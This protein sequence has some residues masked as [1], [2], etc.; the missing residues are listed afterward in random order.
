MAIRRI[1]DQENIVLDQKPQ[2]TT[3]RKIEPNEF[4]TLDQD[5]EVLPAR[6]TSPVYFPK[7]E[8]D[9]SIAGHVKSGAVDATRRLYGFSANVLD[10]AADKADDLQFQA[11]RTYYD[12][13]G[14]PNPDA[15]KIDE[16]TAPE[17]NAVSRGLRDQASEDIRNERILAGQESAMN[18]Q[19]TVAWEE[20]SPFQNEFFEINPA[21]AGRFILEQGARSLPE[22]GVAFI[23]YVGLP[24][25]ATTT[26][27]NIT[28]NRLQNEGK[29]PTEIPT[30]EDMKAALSA[31]LVS[32]GLER[33]GVLGD[34]AQPLGGTAKTVARA[35]DI[36]SAMVRSGAG[37]AGTEFVQE[38]TEY[39]GGSLGTGE[40]PTVKGFIE[41]GLQGALIGG[42]M[43]ATV[44][45]G[46]EGVSLAVQGKPGEEQK[47]LE[48]RTEQNLG[49]DA[50]QQQSAPTPEPGEVVAQIEAPLNRDDLAESIKNDTP[51]PDKK[52]IDLPEVEID[53]AL[54][55]QGYVVGATVEQVDENGEVSSGTVA[56]AQIIDDSL[57][58]TIVD[59]D[60]NLK[61]LFSSNGDIAVTSVPEQQQPTPPPAQQESGQIG[62]DF[63]APLTPPA[64]AAPENPYAAMTFEQLTSNLGNIKQQ[65]KQSGWNK[66]LID[67]RKQINTEIEARFPGQDAPKNIDLLDAAQDVAQEPTDAQKEAGNYKKGHV[68]V[69]GLPVTLENPKGSVR[70]G[71]DASGQE[72]SVTMPA[73]Y[74]YI[75]RTNGADGE[76]ID[77]YIGDQPSSDKVY[78]LDQIDAETRNFDE[79]KAFVGFESADQVKIA[80]NSSFSDGL[81]SQRYGGLTEMTMAEFK[82]WIKKPASKKPLVYKKQDQ[83]ETEGGAVEPPAS[84]QSNLTNPYLSNITDTAERVT[85]LYAQ[86]ANDEVLR[87]IIT[88]LGTGAEAD[89]LRLAKQYFKWLDATPFAFKTA[90][91]DNAGARFLNRSRKIAQTEEESQTDESNNQP[92]AG[93]ESGPETQAQQPSDEADQDTA[94]GQDQEQTEEDQ[95][96]RP[97]KKTRMVAGQERP[98]PK[99]A[100]L[101][102]LYRMDKAVQEEFAAVAERSEEVNDAAF[103]ELEQYA[104]DIETEIERL[105]SEDGQKQQNANQAEEGKPD[106]KKNSKVGNDYFPKSKLQSYENQST[107]SREIL[108]Q[109]TPDDFLK[110]ALPIS[111]ADQSKKGRV[112]EI[113]GRREKFT[114]LPFMSFEHDGNGNAK[115]IAHE[116][117]HRAE[118]LKEFG[119]KTIP[120]VFIS[121]EGGGGQAIRWGEQSNTNSPDVIEGKWPAKLIS[122]NGKESIEF[123]VKDNR[124]KDAV[125]SPEPETPAVDEDAPERKS[126]LK[127]VGEKLEGGRKF[128]ENLDKA[129]VSEKA[130]L[131]IEAT[132]PAQAF[133]Y[134]APEG[135]TSGAVRF[136]QELMRNVYNFSEYLYKKHILKKGKGGRYGRK[137][138][139]WQEQVK[140]FLSDQTTES[141]S[142]EVGDRFYS[143]SMALTTRNDIIAASEEYVEFATKINEIFENAATVEELRI[144]FKRE[145]GEATVFST[146]LD[147][148]AKSYWLTRDIVK[149]DGYGTFGRIKDDTEEKKKKGPEKKLIRPRLE[150]IE[151]ENLKDF[152]AG[153][154]VTPEEFRSTFGFRGVEFGNWVN[155]AEGQAHVNHAYDALMDLARRLKIDPK[156]I[157]IGGKL[158]FAFG[159]RG[160]GEHAAHYEPDTNVINLTKTKGDGSVAHEWAHALDIN[161]RNTGAAGR[162]FMD[163]AYKSLSKKA[164]TPEDL[165]QKIK[166]FLQG[167]IFYQHMKKAGPV[168]NAREHLRLLKSKPSYYALR[169]TQ[170]QKDGNDLSKNYHGTEIELFARAWEAWVYDTL[171]G[172]SPYL[173]SPWVA[174]GAVT[175]ET[176][177]RGTMYP[178]GEERIGFNAMF[179]ELLKS[180]Q[181]TDTGV[182]LKEN[183]KLPFEND[184]DAV[185]KAAD[186]IEG[187]LGQMMK[188][189]EDGNV[190]QRTVQTGIS[191]S[192]GG[193]ST[194]F[195]PPDDQGQDAEA[196]PQGDSGRSGEDV[197]SSI[198]TS[199]SEQ[200]DGAESGEGDSSRDRVQ[201]DD[202]VPSGVEGGTEAFQ[203]KGKNHVISLGDLSES[204][205]QKQKAEDNIKIIKLVKEIEGARRAATPEEQVIIAKFTGWGSIKNAFPDGNGNFKEGW[206]SI[207]TQLKELL[208]DKEY[209]QSR[210]TIQYAHYTSEIV[211]RQMWSAL[212]RFGL[213][214]GNIFEPGMGIGNFVGMM[215]QDLK[216]QYSGLEVD[217]M[218]ARIAAILYPESGVRHAD[219]IAAQYAD[220]MFDAAIGNPPFSETKIRSDKKYRGLS[221]HNYFFAKTLDMVADG[222]VIAFVT[223]RFS[224]DALDSKARA[225]LAEKADLIGAI[226]LPNTAFKTNAHTE[227]VTDIV[228]LRKRLSGEESNGVKW[229]ETEEIDVKDGE[230][231]PFQINEYFVNNPEMVLGDFS[232]TGSMHGAKNALTVNPP[233][234]KDLQQQLEEAIARLPE[235]IVTD[236]ERSS[237][238][239]IDLEPPEAKDGS[240][241]IKDG[242]LMQVENGIG[243]PAP[244]R[245]KAPGGLTKKEAEKVKKLIPVRDAL[246]N[247]LSA[248]VAQNDGLMRK[249]Q[250]KLRKHY[251]AFVKK[252]GPI[253]KSDTV[254]RPPA[255]SQLEEARDEMR[256]D[257]IAAGEEFEEGDIDLSNLLGKKNPETG[258]RY[259]PAQIAKIRQIKRT[260]IE[261]KGGVV[262]EG[263]FDPA[264]VPDNVTISYPNMDAFRAD[265]EYYNFIVLENYDADTDTATTTDVFEKNIVRQVTKPKIETSVDALNYSLAQ[266]NGVDIDF[267]AEES[268]TNRDSLIRELEELD[269]IFSVPNPEGGEYHMYAEEYLSGLVRDKL[270]YAKRLA[271]K[272]QKYQRNVEALQAVQPRDIPASDI[273]TQLGSPYFDPEVIQDFM[274]EE[275][276]IP[277][278][279]TYSPIINGWDVSAYDKYASENTSQHGTKKRPADDLISSLL[280]RKDIKITKKV[281]TESGEKSVVDID[282]TQ[283]AQDKAKALQEKFDNWIWKSKHGERVHRKY[284][285][286][287]NNLVPRRID[288]KHITVAST[289]PLR[290]HQKNAVW[291]I[292]QTGNSYLAHAVGAGKT[293]EMVAAAMEMRRLG[294]WKKPLFVVPNHMLAQFAGEFRIA[295]PQAKI[296]VA[297][298]RNF[299][300]SKRQRFVANVAKG[301]WDGVIMTYSSFKKVPISKEFEAEMIQDEIERYRLALEEANRSKSSGRGSTAARL[302]KQIEKM[303]GRLKGLKLQDVDQGFSFDQLGTDAI[304]LD[305]AHYFRKLSFATMQGN[306]KGVNPIGSKAAWDLYVKAKYL[307][308]VHPGRNLVMASGTP[309]TNTLAEVFTIQRFMNEAALEARNIATFDAWS[310]VYA[311]SVT[312][313]ERQPSG[314]YKNVTRLAEFRNLNSLSQ[315]VREFMDVVTSDE[316]GALVDRPTMKTGTMIIKTTPPTREYL[317]FQKFLAERTK[318]ISNK[319]TNEKGADNILAIINE[320]RHAAIDMRLIDPTLPE[321]RSKL[322]DMIEN[323]FKV[324]KDTA[325]DEFTKI[326]K[327]DEKSDI[328]GGAQLIFSDLGVRSRMKNGQSFSAYDHIR[329]KLIR[330]GVP[331]DEI[332][333]IADYD[334]TEEKRRL[335]AKVRAGEVRIL[336]GSTSKMGTGLNVQNRLKA[337]HNLD[338]PWLPADLEQRTG[339]ALRQGNQY[340]EVEIYGYG[341]EGSYDSTM[342]GMLETKAKAIIQ[343]LKGDTDLTTMR[344]I[345]E[346]DHYRMAKAMTSGDERVLKQAEL[347]SEVEKLARQSKN[348]INEQVQIKSSIASN[349]SSI[350]HRKQL[351]KDAEQALEQ[352]KDFEDEEFL[353]SVNGTPY[354]ERAEAAAALEKSV[355]SVIDNQTSTPSDGVKIADY[356]GFEV[357]MFASIS[358]I[359]EE[360]E[361]FIPHPAFESRANRNDWVKGEK[362]SGSGA[363]TRL[364]NAVNRLNSI[365]QDSEQSIAR[366]EREIKVL[367]SQIND[368]FPKEEELKKKREELAAVEKDLKENAPV[369]VVYDDY[370]LDYW[371]ANKEE[372][373][374]SV[375]ASFYIV[376]DEE[377]SYGR[378]APKSDGLSSEMAEKINN[379]LKSVGWPAANVR[380]S[381][382]LSQEF[383]VSDVEGAYWRGIIHI[384]MQAQDIL[385]TLNHEIIHGLKSFGAF[386]DTEWSVL[387]GRAAGWRKKYN[388]DATYKAVLQEQGVTDPALMERKLNEE[389]IAHAFQDHANKGIVRRLANKAVRFLQTIKQIL[390]GKP[391]NFT[392]AED[393][394]RAVDS[395]EVGARFSGDPQSQNPLFS[396]TQYVPDRFFRKDDPKRFN[397]PVPYKGGR[398]SGFTTPEHSVF[399]GYDKNG[400]QFTISVDRVDPKDIEIRGKHRSAKTAAWLRK[401]LWGQSSA[402]DDFPMY[403]LG[404]KKD[405][406]LR[407]AKKSLANVR[408][409]ETN[410]LSDLKRASSLILHPHQIATLYKEFTPVYRAVI[411]RFKQ[412]EILVHQL[413]KHIDLYNKLSEDSKKNVNAV[414]EIG[415]LAGRTYKPDQSGAVIVK[416]SGFKDTVHSEDGDTITLTPV[417]AQAYL[418]V[419]K[420]LDEALELQIQV[421]LEEYGLRELG[422]KTIQ[423]VEKLRLKAVKE[424]MAAEVRR[425]KQILERLNEVENMRKR[426]YVP[427]KRW[428]EVGVSVKDADGE[429]KYFTRVELPKGWRKKGVIGENKAVQE[430]LDM[431]AEKYKGKDYQINFFEMNKFDEVAAYL[432]LRALDILASSSDMSE[433]D[434]ARLKDMLEREMQKKG[435]RSHFFRSLDVPGY[436]PDF[437]RALNDYV[438]SSASYIARRL[439]ERH[440]DAAVS[441]IAESGKP[442]LY[443]YARGYQ[444]YVNDPKEELAGIRMMG[445]FWYLA[446]NV[447]SGL[448]NMTQPLI[449]TAPWFSAKFG[450]AE[451]GKEM[452]KAYVDAGKTFDPKSPVQEPF[453]FD[454]A[455]ADIRKA[456]KKAQAEGDFLSMATHDAMAISNSTTQSLRGLSKKRRQVADSIA[457]TF[458][459]PE[460]TNR[461][462]TFISAYR[463]AMK[464]ENREKI[465]KFV[466]NDQLARSMLRGQNSAE[467][468]AFAYAELAVVS[469]QYRVGKLNRP[470]LMRGYGSLL[471]QFMSFTTQTFELMYKLAKVNGGR[472]K[473]A[474][475]TMLLSVVAVAGMKGLPFEDDLQDL[476]ETLYKFFTGKELDIDTEIRELLSE[477]TNPVIADTLIRGV[478]AS[479]LNLDLSGRLGFGNVAP[480]RGADFLGPWWDMLYERPKRAAKLANEGQPLAA[481]SEIAPAFIRNP[482]QSLIWA[483]DGVRTRTG[484]KVIDAKDVTTTDAALKFFGFTSAD[485]SKE[486][487]R[488]WA[489]SRANNAV[490]DLRSRYYKKISKTIAERKRLYDSGDKAGAEQMSVQLEAIR[491]EINRYN[492]TAPLHEKIILHEPTIK[493]RLLEEMEGA[494]VRRIRKQARPRSQELKEIYK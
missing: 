476:Y 449:V 208:T 242:A 122:E 297:D 107:K 181:F 47:L 366:S 311:S 125:Q 22:M 64:P 192:D 352:K 330:M 18:V 331:S 147:K 158:G 103:A 461:V 446:G 289:I 203:A 433:T 332:A 101:Q 140:I 302:E 345:E 383:G 256:N 42:P 360:Y 228:F 10:K 98:E 467:A 418:G 85:K 249:E 177:Y 384:S 212:K 50:Q 403:K 180:I 71:K 92:P 135:Q 222:G 117:R 176:G 458:S 277:A 52:V 415:R 239:G 283:A 162:S 338:A 271:D 411:E 55:Q 299:H 370:P 74:G 114:D 143:N 278:K 230:G 464:P 396:K 187:R 379:R 373:K 410:L 3:L 280:M 255:L 204:R 402:N 254:S 318:E 72:W 365:K 357:R 95:G 325:G 16:M 412:R 326:Y 475:A 339:R 432:D 455:P 295:Y 146:M 227:V 275:L 368:K 306:M 153:K 407:E 463:L 457:V 155:A 80:Y 431:L 15:S 397:N 453:D 214:T 154:D 246:R 378:A 428:G 348:F 319:R 448:V 6:A 400:E 333:F 316:L 362:F 39:V 226:R 377:F 422:V 171:D 21:K 430:V 394:F 298:E 241:Y 156:H 131:I 13:F 281:T 268:G 175:K 364:N 252:Y 421:I 37:E 157:S 341:T 145:L 58:V 199:Q 35:R 78:V 201:R 291:R 468:F 429:L 450:L 32:A 314:A 243:Q 150:K 486:R 369:E 454:K 485:I 77:V 136:H 346:T 113:L 376:G 30:N 237:E 196:A 284:N 20:I 2:K 359:I 290:E 279:V 481:A 1:G 41:S 391:Y 245:G 374:N 477:K 313:A 441:S 300:T 186:D 231:N 324:Y 462:V 248:M 223:S 442:D 36:P 388:I 361:I 465:E 185:I 385:G 363:I 26:S 371:R 69:Q 435:F 124:Q 236:I 269:L 386:T 67:A 170:F 163:K 109:M 382:D 141:D 48:D 75:K 443:E 7:Q 488:V 46:T 285:Q 126:K 82:E 96:D 28:E 229:L 406:A 389:A 263:S 380:F 167:K 344:D 262:D 267:M 417:E 63:D 169:N 133:A 206:Q 296:Y 292:L 274:Q 492:Q 97:V 372:I 399:F 217:P 178:I 90:T 65:A 494:R 193:T 99:G 308:T 174:D 293:L 27:Q 142:V 491:D 91:E 138:P 337:V 168:G 129:P 408:G 317:A 189:I 93:D 200:G 5:R 349:K 116:G 144:A 460:K 232:A 23:P 123:P 216:L 14:Y 303:E 66:K 247:V 233:V 24:T 205:S 128:K 33:L 244:M 310:S 70:S 4:I 261:E 309:L 483:N 469:T 54:R 482:L 127:D 215:P 350:D 354:Q 111:G 471:F 367:E 59:A 445:F 61:T 426:G 202:T 335:Q 438:I 390:S 31:G 105:K 329:R 381:D 340:G 130:K 301:D 351:I 489:E 134:T 434:Y 414:L 258:K 272:D 19:D 484:T 198:R 472:N 209:R 172:Q 148:F 211:T 404:K 347:E 276:N 115:I 452:S 353:M 307:D 51:L 68:S 221:L 439:N 238:V 120:V 57:E 321:S 56:A 487:A 401:T 9:T 79:H 161:L 305:E 108:I 257:Y 195:I 213:K 473:M 8:M 87:N 437:E 478:P 440:I 210:R 266:K 447:S 81:A 17:G 334:S 456:L 38:G 265:P 94:Q 197:S 184:L 343:F 224:M 355:Q 235:S 260:E 375:D 320:G 84:D 151:R 183:A 102:A 282:E 218:S 336:I 451:I 264:G 86:R 424:G 179:E 166:R 436:S 83:S 259:T 322:E 40:E 132:K 356:R 323:V 100:T 119:V 173:V 342:W 253:T 225:S 423:D 89:G 49:T 76:Q 387:E 304:L 152:R 240:Y 273:N 413:S 194:E 479:L 106:Q 53:P 409:L 62:F 159:S 112:S 416:N 392:S 234:A 395:G 45:G 470:K 43:G 25:V 294:L 104:R 427:F 393:V 149:D 328:K 29:E 459:V 160:S 312:N 315:M 188:E 73:H 358:N 88:T 493:Q 110:L 288:G 164:V 287:F 220:G 270:A 286:E 405:P 207:G 190:Q 251:D 137:M 11:Q 466:K 34:V 480:D 44:R 182:S 250:A 444:Q 420:M 121:A 191:D 474:L 139:S 425:F 419:R 490:N 165:E 12:I 327:S 60:G 398:L 118:A 219:F